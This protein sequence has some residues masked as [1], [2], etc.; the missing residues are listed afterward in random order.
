M[1]VISSLFISCNVVEIHV[2]RQK[3]YIVHVQVKAHGGAWTVLS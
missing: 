3:T 2:K 1:L